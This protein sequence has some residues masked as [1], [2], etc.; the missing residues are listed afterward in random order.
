MSHLNITGYMSENYWEQ[1]NRYLIRKMLICFFYEKII[2]PEVYNLNNYELNLD[3]QGISYTF[4]AT[5]Y[6]MEYLDI[7]INSIKKTKN[8]KNVNL[9]A[10]LFILELKDKLIIN[11]KVLPIYLDELIATLNSM[12]YKLQAN[13]LNSKELAHANYQTVEASMNEGFPLM[14]AN[15]G[16]HG[17]DSIDYFKYSPECAEKQQ[18]LWIAVHKRKAKFSSISSISY[19]Q[20]IE[21]ELSSQLIEKFREIIDE[22]AVLNDDYYWMPVHQWQWREKISTRFTPDI[23]AKQIIFLGLGDD[24]YL[25]QQSVRTLYNVSHP[26][27]CYVKTALSVINTGFIR[28]LSPISMELSPMAC[29]WVDALIRQDPYFSEKGFRLIK[30]IATISYRDSRIEDVF[31]DEQH[32]EHPY[33]G[34]LSCL[35]RESIVDKIAENQKT[36]TMA[37]MLHIDKNGNA[38][39]TELIQDSGLS[40]TEWINRYLDI[41]FSPLLHAFFC[42][43]LIF[44]PHGENVILVLENNQ[45]VHVFMKDLGE[46]IKFLNAKIEIPESLLRL[47]I[48]VDDDLKVDYI[49]NDVFNGI[50]RF[51]VPILNKAFLFSEQQFWGL[52]KK[53]IVNYQ[54]RY[55]EFADKYHR[56]NLFK[57]DIPLMCLNLMQLKNNSEI[58]DYDNRVQEMKTTQRLCNPLFLLKQEG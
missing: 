25:A 26:E 44:M 39:L 17:F 7:E 16:R 55:P 50:F 52:V 20:L 14:I 34:M 43:D 29:E 38:F 23:A 28:T 53:K 49:F 27:K 31:N 15:Y 4:S 3:E 48:K 37:S 58:V 13:K 30:E 46:E 1:A 47:S 45:P 10:L 41:Y 40:V 19:Q 56:Y 35:W 11:E 18:V 6:W 24:H 8:G 36:I 54:E 12:T 51:L 22:N 32:A 42:Y 21:S 33:K 9:D 2:L 57:P 5:P